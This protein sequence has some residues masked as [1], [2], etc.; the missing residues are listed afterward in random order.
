MTYVEVSSQHPASVRNSEIGVCFAFVAN[1][2]WEEEMSRIFSLAE[3]EF[4]NF[5]RM[6]DLR[7]VK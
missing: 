7:G 2:E 3:A 5:A 4:A 6:K 1:R